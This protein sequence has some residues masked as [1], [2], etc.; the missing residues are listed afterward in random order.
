MPPA[1][2]TSTRE[3]ATAHAGS[4]RHTHCYYPSVACHTLR[5]RPPPLPPPQ[6]ARLAER[7][8]VA[9]AQ[10]T[11]EAQR[12]CG[13]RARQAPARVYI[14]SIYAPVSFRLDV[15]DHSP[16]ALARCASLSAILAGEILA[17]EPSLSRVRWFVSSRW[18]QGSL[19]HGREC[20]P[21]CALDWSAARR[22]E[23]A[24]C[25]ATGGGGRA[26]AG[27]E[28][29]IHM[30]GLHVY[31]MGVLEHFKGSR[32]CAGGAACVRARAAARWCDR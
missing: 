23:T 24:A 19:V 21:R 18:E 31:L 20:S 12:R 4:A 9:R 14:P 29:T 15:F 16:N 11:A 1:P 7:A 30:K 8:C 5:T 32:V 2:T 17:H 10:T 27:M 3:P 25:P 6:A 22:G 28:R 13:G 26:G